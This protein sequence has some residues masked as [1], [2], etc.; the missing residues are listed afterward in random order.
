MLRTEGR[1]IRADRNR[2][3]VQGKVPS[4]NAPDSKALQYSREML[5]QKLGSAKRHR[6]LE[7]CCPA[8]QPI[9]LRLHRLAESAAFSHRF[10]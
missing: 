2:M 5:V 4:T 3:A 6:D 1:W 7:R 8:E 9:P 10:L